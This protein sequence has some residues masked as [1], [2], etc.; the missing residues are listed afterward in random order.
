MP[1]RNSLSELRSVS[2]QNDPNNFLGRRDRDALRGLD[3][4]SALPFLDLPSVSK[5]DLHKAAEFNFGQLPSLGSS[6]PP[7]S[8]LV[9]L[10]KL[11]FY[12]EELQLTF[13]TLSPES[14]QRFLA[15]FISL[16]RFIYEY[17]FDDEE[18]DENAGW[19]SSPFVPSGINTALNHL[20]DSLQEIS[21]IY[22]WSYHHLWQRP[23]GSL[24]SFKELRKLKA[25]AGILLGAREPLMN[26]EK[27]LYSFTQMREF[28]ERLPPSLENLIIQH[29]DLG[30]I[31]FLSKY[32]EGNRV[33]IPPALKVIDVVLEWEAIT[34]ASED[35]AG[36]KEALVIAQ[37][38]LAH[39]N[40]SDR[41]ILLVVRE[42][43]LEYEIDLADLLKDLRPA[44][45]SPPQD[46]SDQ[47]QQ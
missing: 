11:N 3:L 37:F 19:E 9:P 25:S 40:A 28:T 47:N 32:L 42:G 22:P 6:T 31:E 43:E 30:I 34:G 24:S 5:V 12:A 2:I 38:K 7:T 1:Y 18:W 44:P 17:N 13:S 23:I 14:L 29:C 4:C 36:D 46:S 15:Y 21:I 39:K 10:P 41:G 8:D 16:R 45:L 27:A 26:D 20:R 33:E 35:Y